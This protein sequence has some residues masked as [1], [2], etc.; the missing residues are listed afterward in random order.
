MAIDQEG[1]GCF[2]QERWQRLQC[3]CW[4]ISIDSEWCEAFFI[5]PRYL[6]VEQAY[7]FFIPQCFAVEGDIIDTYEQVEKERV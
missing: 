2:G 5:H 1:R 4:H 7:N 3:T 6:E